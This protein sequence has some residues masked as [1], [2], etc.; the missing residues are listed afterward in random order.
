LIALIVSQFVPNGFILAGMISA[1]NLNQIIVSG[2]I[3]PDTL[4]LFFFSWF[5]FLFLVFLKRR[6]LFVLAL[7]VVC[8]GISA[9]TRSTGY[10]IIFPLFVFL[11]IYVMVKPDWNLRSGLTTLCV[12]IV[13][14]SI[15]VSPV[16]D[17]NYQNFGAFSYTTQGGSHLIG[18]VVPMVRHLSD[19]NTF[20][21][22]QS[23]MNEKIANSMEMDGIEIND[24][25][26]IVSSYLTKVAVSELMDIGVVKVVYAWVVGGLMNLSGPSVMVMPVVKSLKSASFYM[27]PGDS[28]IDKFVNFMINSD[29]WLYV[30]LSIMGIIISVVFVLSYIGGIFVITR[31]RVDYNAWMLAFIVMV[32]LYFMVITGPVLGV[33]YRIPVEPILTL[34]SV[35]SIRRFFINNVFFRR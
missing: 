19:G 8:L 22:H 20:Q 31:N 13:A 18:W 1:V 30:V 21:Y 3:L 29:S 24:N 17:R 34:L 9:L 16:L 14:I 26:F 32:F 11:M 6:S 2:M 12:Y 27:T 4:F 15:I 25:P 35:V 10:F 7:S 33:K 28:I 23:K 5:I